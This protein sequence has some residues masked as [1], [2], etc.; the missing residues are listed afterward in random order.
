V[1]MFKGNDGVVYGVGS[2]VRCVPE[3][4][5]NGDAFGNTY[6]GTVYKITRAPNGMRLIHMR[7]DDTGA[8]VIGTARDFE[9]VRT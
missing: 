8:D 5:P 6:V 3:R 9:R 7:R 1:K 4:F 2:R